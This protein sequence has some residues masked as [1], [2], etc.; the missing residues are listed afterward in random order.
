MVYM[1]SQSLTT[2][3]RDGIE[4][5]IIEY[6]SVKSEVIKLFG[7]YDSIERQ[8]TALH[9]PFHRIY[10]KTKNKFLGKEPPSISDLL[11]LQ[12]GIISRLSSELSSQVERTDSSL[13]SLA[14]YSDVL[15]SRVCDSVGSR[16]DSIEVISRLRNEVSSLQ[17]SLASHK[18]DSIEYYSCRRELKNKMRD[19]DSAS[20]GYGLSNESIR[21]NIALSTNIVLREE[22]LRVSAHYARSLV[23]ASDRYTEFLGII[24]GVY[25]DFLRQD[26]LYASLVNTVRQS[27]GFI[28]ALDGIVTNGQVHTA[29]VVSTFA[30]PDFK[31]NMLLGDS[32]G[33]LRE[34]YAG[35]SSEAESFVDNYLRG[36]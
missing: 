12:E 31:S 25:A 10:A 26:K 28:S 23:G 21:D 11:R 27:R 16:K 4:G 3:M 34:L 18:R 6:D 8:I 33:N 14:E 20:A 15:D 9:S 22:L 1:G 36:K 17:K 29:R 32:A 19:F 5:C 7:N 13:I 24:K 30:D 35:R 2:M